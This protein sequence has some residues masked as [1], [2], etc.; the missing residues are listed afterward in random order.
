MPK[1]FY[2][3]PN[4]NSSGIEVRWTKSAQRIDISG[5]YN[6]F[7]GLEGGSLSLKE[8]FDKLGITEQD[9]KKAFARVAKSVD[10]TDLKSVAARH[11]GSIPVPRT[12]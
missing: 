6:S 12:K 1:N 11:T 9:C 5:W 2:L 4:C 8:F 7:V 3:P 10:A